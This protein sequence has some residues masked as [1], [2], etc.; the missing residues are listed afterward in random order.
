MF[1]LACLGPHC[2]GGLD[3]LQERPVCV[4]LSGKQ[5]QI[6][7]RLTTVGSRWQW[8]A[9]GGAVLLGNAIANCYSRSVMVGSRWQLVSKWWRCV[10]WECYGRLLDAL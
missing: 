1:A 9:N 8:V 10:I 2:N 5:L 6:A 4:L 3:V 7:R